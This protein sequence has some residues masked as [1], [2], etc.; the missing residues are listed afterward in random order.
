MIFPATT[1]FYAALFALL[2]VGLSAWVVATRVSADVLHGDGGDDELEKRIRAQGNFGEYVPL[3][4]LLV[5]LLEAGGSSSTLVR[6]LL[7]ILLVAR[8]LHPVGMLAPKNSLQQ[9]VCRGGGII[10]TFLVI[11][12]AAVAL[13]LR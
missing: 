2:Y 4:L 6:T 10:A 9:Y 8:I 7:P 12:V 3:A 11:A 5:T 13:L 1:A